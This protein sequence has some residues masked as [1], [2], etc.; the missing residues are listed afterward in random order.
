MVSPVFT[1]ILLLALAG[2]LVFSCFS[3]LRHRKIYNAVT[4]AIAL[5]APAYWIA[6]GESLWPH[7]ALHLGIAVTMFLLFAIFFRF[8]MMGGGDVKLIGALALWFPLV[9]VVEMLFLT[10]IIGLIVTIGFWA[11]HKRSRQLGQPRIPYGI[12]ISLAAL[13]VIGEPYF[14]QFR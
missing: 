1:H 7:M 12:A 2:A 11:H 13:W 9:R 4:L 8:G 5:S 3:D 6:N 14:N 10:S